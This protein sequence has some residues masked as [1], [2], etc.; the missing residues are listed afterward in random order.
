MREKNENKTISIFER[1]L[2]APEWQTV[3][4]TVQKKKQNWKLL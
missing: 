4:E 1:S 3:T 2:L